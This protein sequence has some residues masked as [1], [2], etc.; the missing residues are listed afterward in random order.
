MSRLTEWMRVLRESLDSKGELSVGGESRKERWWE[1]SQVRSSAMAT[2]EAIRDDRA[3]M[4][5]EVGQKNLSWLWRNS[6][7]KGQKVFCEE[8]KNYNLVSLNVARSFKAAFVN[9]S[10]FR[11]DV[12]RSYFDGISLVTFKVLF[13]WI[14]LDSK[15]VLIYFLLV[16]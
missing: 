16:L 5:K 11:K 14:S 3:L 2:E 15:S 6:S 10:K 7:V 13:F 8:C 9:L 4:C 12:L 1:D